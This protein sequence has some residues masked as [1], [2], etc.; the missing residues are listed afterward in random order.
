MTDDERKGYE[1]II[2]LQE[3]VINQLIESLQHFIDCDGLPCV[4]LI[5]EAAGIRAEILRK[6]DV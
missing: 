3:T 2:R 5:N 6:K 4:K 1:D